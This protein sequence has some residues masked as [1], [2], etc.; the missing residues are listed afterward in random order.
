[1]GGAGLGAAEGHE[2]CWLAPQGTLFLTTPP[3][4]GHCPGAC[5]IVRVC[6]ANASAW[7]SSKPC[8]SAYPHHSRPEPEPATPCSTDAAEHR[9]LS[10]R[11]CHTTAHGAGQKQHDGTGH[12]VCHRARTQMTGVGSSSSAWWPQGQ[13]LLSITSTLSS[14][15]LHTSTGAEETRDWCVRALSRPSC[16]T[17]EPATAEG[18]EGQPIPCAAACPGSTSSAEH[19][20]AAPSAASQHPSPP[21]AI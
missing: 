6:A 13:G 15:I 5:P 21:S 8:D 10:H 3:P 18:S 9:A 2:G 19:L 1:M 14:S 11:C 4:Q 17:I 20:R 12:Q 7:G 16:E